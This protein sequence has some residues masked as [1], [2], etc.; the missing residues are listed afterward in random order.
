MNQTLKLGFYDSGFG[1]LSVLNEFIEEFGSS[2]EYF[3]FGD[4]ANAPYGNKSSDELISLVYKI[5][6]F[7]E[8]LKVDYLI[9]ACNTSSALLHKMDLKN[10]SFSIFNLFDLM[11]DYF[12]KNIFF[13]RVGFLATERTIKSERYLDWPVDIYPLACPKLVPLV[14]AGRMEEARSEFYEYLLEFPE[15]IYEVLI[16]CTHYSFLYQNIEKSESYTKRFKFIDPAKLMADYFLVKCLD[17][18]LK[19]E[20]KNTK[21]IPKVYLYSSGDHRNFLRLSE[22]LLSKKAKPQT[23]QA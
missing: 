8:N 5:F 10:Y 22:S 1:G 6:D 11:Q 19:Y 14:E 21:E 13:E 7:M 16:G 15:N 12:S 2:F 3:Y 4:S 17:E 23:P 18:N 20:V 9:S